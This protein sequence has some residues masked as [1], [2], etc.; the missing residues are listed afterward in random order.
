ME[1]KISYKII[2]LHILQISFHYSIYQ[3]FF[4][5]YC[6][7]GTVVDTGDGVMDK[8]GKALCF[9]QHPFL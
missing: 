8:T 6:V 1:I 7:S 2:I 5:T 4:C 9:L 3:Y